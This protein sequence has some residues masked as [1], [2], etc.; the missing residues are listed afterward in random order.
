MFRQNWPDL[1]RAFLTNY[2]RLA[3][4]DMHIT[5]NYL[6]EFEAVMGRPKGSRKR[7]TLGWLVLLFMTVAGA[8]HAEN[9]RFYGML[10][11]R[12]LTP[13]GFLRLDM[14]PA[15][16]IAIEPESFA[17]EAEL[18]YQNTWALSRNVET[19]LNGL[20]EQGVRREIGPE[21]IQAILDL[22]GENYLLDLESATLD[23]T[24]HYK[25]SSQWSAYAILTA[26]SYHGGFM[27]SGIEK[28]HETLG[29]STFGRHAVARNETNLIYDLKGAQVVL[30]D[31]PQTSGFMDPT[32]GLRY[33]GFA[34][35]GRWQ[36]SVE[37]AVKVPLEGERLLLST[38]RTDY[39]MQA[40]VRRLGR[41]NAL[42][43]DFAAVYYAG[44]DIP[45]P[46]DAQV[47]PTLVVGW[48][49]QVSARTNLNLQGYA[50]RSVYRR[51]QTDLA[52]LLSEKFQLSLGVRHRF[53]CCLVSFA[54]TEN[55]QNLNNT[56]DIGFQLGFG[57]VPK[58]RPQP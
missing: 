42:H 41:K 2:I 44:E 31:A 48:E 6:V 36:M 24:M 53:D 3:L 49:R 54:V 56:P 11:E 5:T 8:A 29:F 28:F 35:P 34:L 37:A 26:V 10:R 47:I 4:F 57:W 12:D 30:L 9:G 1:N 13:F 32:F 52:E 20:E 39:G 15:H 16:A 33:A 22:P 55:L 45:S 38:G 43:I 27:D 18:G 17:F 21:E 23:L 40:S 46:H 19:Y 51:E 58:I 7:E 25:I 50:S 14:R